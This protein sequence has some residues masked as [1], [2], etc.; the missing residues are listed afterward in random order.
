MET[1]LTRAVKATELR[2]FV[3]AQHPGDQLRDGA[4]VLHT[5]IQREW[6]YV[7]VIT[8]DGHFRTRRY[9][10]NQLVEVR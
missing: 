9:R 10:H 7:K 4:F 1:T 2:M 5:S 6:V 3:D 8:L